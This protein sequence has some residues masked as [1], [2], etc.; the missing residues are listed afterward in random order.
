MGEEQHSLIPSGSTAATAGGAF[1][2]ATA[3]LILERYNIHAPAGYEALL[4]GFIAALA[5]YIPRSG[6]LPKP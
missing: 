5:G 6:R 3:M 1:I 4:G 2:A